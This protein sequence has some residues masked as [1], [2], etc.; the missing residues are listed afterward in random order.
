M[1]LLV[2]GIIPLLFEIFAGFLAGALGISMDASPAL[3]TIAEKARPSIGI[4]LA[5]HPSGTVSGAA[6]VIDRAI[7][8]TSFHVVAGA[9]Q[10]RV[11]FPQSAWLEPTIVAADASNDLAILA[12]PD[13]TVAPLQLD[14]A[15]TAWAGDDVLAFSFPSVADLVRQSQDRDKQAQAVLVTEA[16]VRGFRDGVLLF[17]PKQ[18]LGGDG[19]P[20]LNL[21]GHVVG[22]A[23]GQL[24]GAEA[25]TSYA[26]P[27]DAARPL[28]ADAL[29]RRAAPPQP[30][31]TAP[32]VAPARPPLVLASPPSTSTAPSVTEG[33][34]GGA[35]TAPTQQQALPPAPTK[36]K[37]A[38]SA[39][40]SPA[41]AQPQAPPP[42][43]APAQAQTPPRTPPPAP[44]APTPTR[45]PPP[46]PV[47]PTRPQTP[48]RTT[49][50][51]PAPVSADH[52][53]VVP[54]QRI[55]AAK[56]GMRDQDVRSALGPPASANQQNGGATVVRWYKPPRNDGIGAE[57]AKDGTVDRVWALNDARFT[58]LKNV[59]IGS[60]EA[61]LR[62]ALGA[63]S[64]V[65]VDDA[66]KNKILI[67]R[68]LGIFFY[69]QLD[70]KLLFYNQVFEIGVMGH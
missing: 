68:Q 65:A 34:V 46:A 50:A 7:A 45:T 32:P 28:L 48:P 60:T 41:A 42:T 59:H 54:G 26:A 39:P 67:Y 61:Q 52:F 12:I 24:P 43:P 18:R 66:R 62:A 27:A 47:A 36:P 51:T 19:G 33:G 29:R 40:P 35:G 63:P 16:T 9:S 4:V 49:A 11:K 53:T 6:F 55:G 57:V 56:L 44:V 30:G 21:R 13:P 10:L 1:P 38:S 25:A 70:S 69:I 22:V 2:L 14:D 20:I 23:R 64:T 37:T 3:R 17:Q 8:V 15:S 5:D 58:T 31:S